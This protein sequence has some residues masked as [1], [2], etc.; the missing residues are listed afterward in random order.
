MGQEAHVTRLGSFSSDL[1]SCEP[2]ELVALGMFRAN[3]RM[4][5]GS[6]FYIHFLDICLEACCTFKTKFFFFSTALSCPSIR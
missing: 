2:R 5:R 4:Q 6:I 1:L 3:I